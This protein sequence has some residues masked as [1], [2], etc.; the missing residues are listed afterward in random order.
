[1]VC[2]QVISIETSNYFPNSYAV[3]IGIKDYLN[4]K[5]LEYTENDANGMA[6]Y[7]QSEGYVVKKFL[8]N[9]ATK[10]EILRYL[11]DDL[12][13]AIKEGDRVVIYFSG[14]GVTYKD[15]GRG[16][17]VPY[18]GGDKPSTLISM[19]KLKEISSIYR[20][21]QHQLYI[22]DAC[23]S[24]GLATKSSKIEL[25][26]IEGHTKKVARQILTAGS[27]DE[28]TPSKSTL[29]GYKQYSHYTSHLIKGL[30]DGHADKYEDGIITFGELSTYLETAA[31][32]D[33]NTPVD[34]VLVGH[35]HGNYVFS[36]PN[37]AKI[38]SVP[39]VPP[40]TTFKST[41]ERYDWNL[42]SKLSLSGLEEYADKYPNG[43]FIKD[44]NEKIRYLKETEKGI[45]VPPNLT[46]A[47]TR[48]K[49]KLTKDLIKQSELEWTQN[50]QYS[51][52]PKVI[53]SYL[54]KYPNGPMTSRAERKLKKL[55]Q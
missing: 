8:S 24:G 23:F 42:L 34:A 54:N 15:T 7:F 27:D 53:E 48:D 18:D 36:S 5:D 50:I 6:E 4:H 9:E 43:R 51:T 20:K 12:P 38:I 45:T 33:H 13:E 35:G 2:Q 30:R 29:P 37:K 1:M 10:S 44:V 39:K 40:G 31:R 16:Y 55:K 19:T 46:P 26:Y 11:E 14:H 47:L 41:D 17:I 32:T 49:S 28:Y 25:K 3:V 21:A 22:L 52:D